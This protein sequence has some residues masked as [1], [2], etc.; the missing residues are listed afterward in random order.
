VGGSGNTRWKTRDRYHPA[1]LADLDPD[2]HGLP[3]G[4]PAG[5]LGE[6]EQHHGR[7]R[8]C[9]PR[10]RCPAYNSDARALKAAL[11]KQLRGGVQ[12]SLLDLAREVAGR[13]AGPDRPGERADEF[14]TKVP[15]GFSDKRAFC[16]RMKST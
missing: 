13:P 5:V 8:Y 16:W 6:G 4:I 11:E 9:P 14:S 12:G 10:R 2:F 1:V 15:V 3:L 7:L